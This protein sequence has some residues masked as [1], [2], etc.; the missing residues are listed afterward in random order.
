MPMQDPSDDDGNI[1]PSILPPVITGPVN[2]ATGILI[3][4]LL[5]ITLAPFQSGYDLHVSTDYEIIDVATGNVIWSSIN[6][7]TGLLNVLVPILTLSL[8][9]T[10]SIRA[11]FNGLNGSSEWGTAITVST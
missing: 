2:G 9:R 7:L 4:V 11:R 10:Y 3:A 5:P 1:W 8:G 6:N